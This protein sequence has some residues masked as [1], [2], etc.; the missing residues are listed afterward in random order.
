MAYLINAYN[1]VGSVSSF[2]MTAIKLNGNLINY[3]D[4][5]IYRR[6][7]KFCHLNV[8]YYE[9]QRKFKIYQM[10]PSENYKN[11]MFVWSNDP[12]K[13]RLMIEEKCINNFTIIEPNI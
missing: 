9:F 6:S 8:E 2:L 11:E 5:D 3:W 13:F 7:E 4:Y 10:K 12:K 1:L